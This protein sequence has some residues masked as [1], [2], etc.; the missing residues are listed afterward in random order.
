M[1]ILG[2]GLLFSNLPLSESV[3]WD[4]LIYVELEQSPLMFGEIPVVFVSV[5]D[6]AGK[7][8]SGAEVTVRLGADS[9]MTYMK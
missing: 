4:L 7:P 9:I 5:T 6:H 2:I 3:L 1:G 8:V